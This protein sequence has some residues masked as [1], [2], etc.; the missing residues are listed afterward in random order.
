MQ[1]QWEPSSIAFTTTIIFRG[2]TRRAHGPVAAR[3][4]AVG[5]LRRKAFLWAL[6]RPSILLTGGQALADA[7]PEDEKTQ[8]GRFQW[9][10]GGDSNPRYGYPYAAFRVRC[11]QPLSHLSAWVPAFAGMAVFL[12]RFAPKK[13]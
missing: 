2:C 10:K 4:V 13:N 12:T 5:P 9:R 1:R 6:N 11:F 8:P 7:S 3:D